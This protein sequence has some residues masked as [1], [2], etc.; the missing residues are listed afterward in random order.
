[1]TKLKAA[2]PAQPVGYYRLGL[3]YVVQKKHDQAIAEF[4]L[5]LKKTPDAIEP[6]TAIV[7]ILLEQGKA[8]KAVARINEAIQAVPGNLMA[9]SLL[10]NVYT[11]QKKFAEAEAAL[12]KVT[13]INQRAPGPYVGLANLYLMRG[14]T[15][16]AI[17]VLQQGLGASPGDPLLLS[18]A[19]AETYQRAGDKE[20]AIAEYEK[21]LK[22]NPRADVAANN[23]A[24]L[25]SEVKSN[26][27]N[28]DRALVLA[29]RF[30]N[31]SNPAFL[32][33][34]G[35]VYF[36]LGENERALPFLQKAV[37]MDPK[38]PALQYHL[39][40]ALYKQGDMKAAKTH[41][42]L[43]VDAKLDFPGIE[44]ANGILAKM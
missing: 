29:K 10:A 14:D 31:A 2:L 43:A 9:Y 25:L 44:E 7:S 37:T 8:D 4:E 17:D 27:A 16:G 13:Q 36:L 19:L 20:K 42:Q 26:K 32:D 15:T 24:G 18:N 41:L 38:A 40:M 21:I 35:W 22:K 12:R 28:L 5:A 34:L 23:L 33:T 6:L 3:L 1:M 39:G 11:R 30:E